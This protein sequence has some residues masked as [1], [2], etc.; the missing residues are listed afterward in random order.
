MR[1]PRFAAISFRLMA[2]EPL[3]VGDPVGADILDRIS[4]VLSEKHP[5]EVAVDIPVAQDPFDQPIVRGT[6]IFGALRA[7]LADYRLLAA[8]ELRFRSISSTEPVA[9]TTKRQATLADLLCGSDPE[10]IDGTGARM[11]RP[12]ALR[13]VSSQ[14]TAGE[15]SDGMARTA[16]SRE[17]GAAEPNKLFRRGQLLGATIEV[18]L[19]IDLAI[20]DAVL[21]EWGTAAV[22]TG[23][24]AARQVIDDLSRALGAWKPFI[25]GQTC[26]GSG[27]CQIAGI[28]LR[29]ADPL[30]IQ[31]LLS[32]SDTLGLLRSATRQPVP[33]GELQLSTRSQGERWSIDVPLKCVDPLLV[34][35][36]AS[37][38]GTHD[39]LAT[40]LD[41]VPGSS[42]RG[43]FRA[44]AEYILRSCGVAEVCESSVGTCGRCATCELFGWVPRPTDPAGR[45]GAQGL[46]RFSDSVVEGSPITLSHAPI[47]RFTGGAADAKFFK[48]KAWA[49][50]AQ[51]TMVVEQTPGRPPVP[52][53][54]RALL[55][56]VLRDIDAG[57]IGL[58][59]STTRGYG[60]LKVADHGVLPAIP[61][62]WLGGVPRV[63]GAEVGQR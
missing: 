33:V 41:I 7:H 10:E 39:N 11:L 19:Q 12:S 5:D 61:A 50:G 21:S 31:Q 38:D 14:L 13:L 56:L 55:S 46:I 43:L 20:L 58:G 52:A 36:V 23:P 35:P 8:R 15:V 18:L 26:V 63:E 37:S 60:T 57:L 22:T 3:T 59:N 62:G 29:W 49:P 30:P 47:D 4:R 28:T 44:R 27:R 42:W 53:W 32:S 48:R 24:T 34:S 25:G 2:V 6:S 17:R 51:L 16:I 9:R 1:S 54:A 40:T 45:A